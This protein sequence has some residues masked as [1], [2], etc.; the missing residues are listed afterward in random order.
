MHAC[1]VGLCGHWP[2]C[3][4]VLAGNLSCEEITQ[5]LQGLAFARLP[6]LCRP[7]SASQLVLALVF[8]PP[9]AVL[10]GVNTLADTQNF[11]ELF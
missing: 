5:V 1:G 6:C 3:T 4:C 8:K 10:V 9:P 7:R 2:G 11:A